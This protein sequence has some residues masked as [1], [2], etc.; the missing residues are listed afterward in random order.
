MSRAE[1]FRAGSFLEDELDARGMTPADFAQASG[2]DVFTVVNIFESIE[3]INESTAQS[4]SNVL[5][6]SPDMWINLQE[7]E[8]RFNE[9]SN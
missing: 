5:G 7:A 3:K 9:M 6:T 8:D 1:V 4:I 2:I